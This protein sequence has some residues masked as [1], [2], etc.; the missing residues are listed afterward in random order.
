MPRLLYFIILGLLAGCSRSP[1]TETVSKSDFKA[2]WPFQFDEGTL[3][4]DPPGTAVVIKANGNT[5]ALN[6]RSRGLAL[7]RGYIDPDSFRVRESD[8]QYV[9]G[10]D[11]I[12]TLIER[13]VAICDQYY[14]Q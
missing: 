6:G 1:E 4:C 7:E 5:Y 11:T 14:R 2:D 8:G 10:T 12:S 3:T 13:G 9:K